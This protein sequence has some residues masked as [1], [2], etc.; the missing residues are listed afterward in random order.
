M[1]LVV[2]VLHGFAVV[3]CDARAKREARTPPLPFAD[4]FVQ[5]ARRVAG[6]THGRVR[7]GEEVQHIAQSCQT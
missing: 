2:R 4:A 5:W 6:A 3:W 1:W 7:Y